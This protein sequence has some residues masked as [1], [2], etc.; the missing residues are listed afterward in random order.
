MRLTTDGEKLYE[1]KE[2]EQIMSQQLKENHRVLKNCFLVRFH[3]D[4]A[5]LF[6]EEHFLCNRSTSEANVRK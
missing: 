2:I 5:K 3:P 1:V 6:L 4:E